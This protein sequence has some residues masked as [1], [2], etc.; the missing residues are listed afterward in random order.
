MT[1]FLSALGNSIVTLEIL[2][3]FG[4]PDK[5]AVV[6]DIE[7]RDAEEIPYI[8]LLFRGSIRSFRSLGGGTGGR[9]TAH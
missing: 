3:W 4:Q 2:S 9:Q 8:F 5:S 6:S 1:I 7:D